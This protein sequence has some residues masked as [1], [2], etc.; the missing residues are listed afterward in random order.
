LGK[1]LETRYNAWD[2]TTIPI[3]ICRSVATEWVAM[4]LRGRRVLTYRYAVRF[5]RAIVE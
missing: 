3:R 5:D 4:D 1:G 2:S